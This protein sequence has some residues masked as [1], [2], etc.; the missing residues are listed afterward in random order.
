MNNATY[1]NNVN[2][3]ITPSGG[4]FLGS[5]SDKVFFTDSMNS[6][7]IIVNIKDAFSITFETEAI[8][9]QSKETNKLIE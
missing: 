6:K 9:T 8:K 5:T 4:D 1:A 7:I 2:D 3:V